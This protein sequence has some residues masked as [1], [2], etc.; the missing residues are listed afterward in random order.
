M[1]RAGQILAVGAFASCCT[2]CMSITHTTQSG[3]MR[4]RLPGSHL[5]HVRPVTDDVLIRA[6]VGGTARL[7]SAP[8]RV[9]FGSP[10]YF[11]HTLG[12]VVDAAVPYF[13]GSMLLNVTTGDPPAA[14]GQPA[15]PETVGESLQYGLRLRVTTPGDRI[16]LAGLLEGGYR[17]FQYTG[18]V[19]EVCH[20]GFPENYCHAVDDWDEVDHG[21]GGDHDDGEFYAT[22][23]LLPVVRIG[24]ARYLYAGVGLD[25]MTTGWQEVESF[26]P[27]SDEVTYYDASVFPLYVGTDFMLAKHVSLLL[28]VAFEL[29]SIDVPPSLDAAVSVDF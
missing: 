14:A 6:A 12:A 24:E 17:S 26:G 15:P 16:F 4:S 5:I 1:A 21:H 11:D 19:V 23:A 28:S 10:M 2:G 22:A 25:Q 20:S 27:D 9:K 18:H 3:S 8:A 13:A 7:D 29:G